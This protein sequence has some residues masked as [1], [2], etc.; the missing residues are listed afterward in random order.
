MH[1]TQPIKEGN[2]DAS[3]KHAAGNRKK[4][5]FLAKLDKQKILHL[6][7]FPGLAW[8]VIFCYIP[9]FG[10]QIAFKDYMF[11]KGI[12][13]SP[14]VGLANFYDFVTDPDIANVLLNTMGISL[15]KVFLMFP[16]PI[17]L[18]IMLNEVPNM[19]Y[20]KVV[21]TIS[22]FPYFISWVIVALMANTWL[23]PS[24]GFVNNF[25]VGAGILKE[26]YF[27]LGKAD[28]FWW[29]S[30]ALETWKNAGWG[31]IIYIA[32]ISGIEQD[33]YEAAE[34]DG[35]RRLQKI[36]HITL[37]SILGTIMIMFILNIGNMLSGGLYASNF[38]V[39]YLLGNPLNLPRSQILDTYILQIG[40][41][42]GRYSYATA[43]GL[44]S[45]M[46][47]LALLL[48]ANK[49]SKKITGE[50]FF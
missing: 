28:A 29:V 49:A 35:A 41:S 6:M 16:I 1:K 45:G 43:V 18:A 5:E 26:P 36:W 4:S 40:I 50:S 32:A 30:L 20:K 12:L 14:W 31:S 44:L 11:N 39:S 46:V 37:P 8:L 42:L 2:P 33:L 34:I 19:A 9:M 10:L 3:G 38:Q 17:L 15:M 23:S 27:F 21:Q 22:Y 13:F 25:L 24:T 7:A 47:S 48:S